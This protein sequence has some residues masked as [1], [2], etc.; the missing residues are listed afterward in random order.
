VSP[1]KAGDAVLSVDSPGEAAGGDDGDGIYQPTKASG[2]PVWPRAVGI[3]MKVENVLSVDMAMSNFVAT[4]KVSYEW[5]LTRHEHELW[6]TDRWRSSGKGRPPW[7]PNISMPSVQKIELKEESPVPFEQDGSFFSVFTADGKVCVVLYTRYRCSFTETYELQNFPFDCQDL[8]FILESSDASK[9][10]LKPRFKR[11][12]FVSIDIEYFSLQEWEL[13]PPIV[14][15]TGGHRAN[16]NSRSG[17]SESSRFIV[18]VKMR[19]RYHFYVS[20]IMF[21]ACMLTFGSLMTWSIPLHMPHRLILCFTILLTL[22]AFQMAIANKLP[23]VKYFTLM[24]LYLVMS[25]RFICVVS[26][27]HALL[28]RLIKKQDT[29]D[30]VFLCT[31]AFWVAMQ[32]GFFILVRVRMRLEDCKLDIDAVRMPG[33]LAENQAIASIA[34]AEHYMIS[35]KSCDTDVDGNTERWTFRGTDPNSG[36][37]INGAN[38]VNSSM[39][40]ESKRHSVS[41]LDSSMGVSTIKGH[42]L[43]DRANALPGVEEV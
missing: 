11:T 34:Q 38:S 21:L 17:R 33:W 31:V 5:Q 10:V 36:P 41:S 15:I 14:T 39:G 4:F 18:Q 19:R 23:L 32:V 2:E 7:V 30:I 24:D 25:Q 26:L 40:G 22:I 42:G 20:R 13:R 12:D 6:K 29:D 43:R 37:V 1:A 9:A 8:T 3:G 16:K 35:S 28:N 27:E